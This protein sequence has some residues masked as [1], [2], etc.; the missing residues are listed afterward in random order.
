MLDYVHMGYDS[1]YERDTFLDFKKGMLVSRV[2]IENTGKN[3]YRR[4]YAQPW[5]TYGDEG[6]TDWGWIDPRL[7]NYAWIETLM[8]S[9]APFRTRGGFSRQ[10]P[11]RDH[12]WLE[13]QKAKAALVVYEIP[14][15]WSD[16]IPLHTLPDGEPPAD[17]KLVE[18][19][20]RF[21]KNGERQE[22]HVSSIRE[23]KPSEALFH[24]D[25]PEFIEKWRNEKNAVQER[26][27][28][29]ATKAE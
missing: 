24:T 23:L 25:F 8:D 26:K 14:E 4:E 18:I 16:A 29:E 19:E 13:R 10:Q 27:A 20:C 12:V 7:F 15:R 21:V 5:K 28:A 17:G 1:R 6:G 9:G 22:L 3:L 11:R 2:D